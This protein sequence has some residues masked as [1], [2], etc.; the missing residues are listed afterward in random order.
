VKQAKEPSV[1]S[2]RC[3]RCGANA[4]RR[5]NRVRFVERVLLPWLGFYPWECAVCRRKTFFRSDGHR[6]MNRR[7]A[8]GNE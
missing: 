3:A 5:I 6:D 2:K 8:S 4:F 7:P 1:K